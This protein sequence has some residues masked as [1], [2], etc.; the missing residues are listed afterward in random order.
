MLILIFQK[1]LNILT[2]IYKLMLNYLIS[3]K[4]Y[5]YDFLNVG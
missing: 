1:T 2:F 5:V 4:N 3:F